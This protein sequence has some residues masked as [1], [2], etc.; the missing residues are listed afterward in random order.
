MRS[1]IGILV[2]TVGALCACSSPAPD[3]VSRVECERLRDHLVDLRLETVTEEHA[4]FRAVIHAALA[5]TVESC[6]DTMTPSRLRCS[7]A[8]TD[9]DA[10]AA[11]AERGAS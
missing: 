4:R 11:C 6:V 8:A 2:L 5:D 1:F 10:L 7:L 9:F 3:E